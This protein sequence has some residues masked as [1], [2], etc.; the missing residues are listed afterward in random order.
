[1]DFP[2]SK[3]CRLKIVTSTVPRSTPERQTLPRIRKSKIA[4]SQRGQNS[5]RS[6]A[7]ERSRRTRQWRGALQR[8]IDRDTYQAERSE[9]ERGQP[10]SPKKKNCDAAIKLVRSRSHPPRGSEQVEPN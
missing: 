4:L 10:Q 1:M 6:N 2:A 9:H 3:P 8:G 5:N 7:D